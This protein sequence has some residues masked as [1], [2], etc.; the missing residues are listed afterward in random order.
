[1]IL[2]MRSLAGLGIGDRLDVAGPAP[3]WLE[4][5]A[6]DLAVADLDDLGPSVWELPD[7]VG[8]CKRSM[9]GFVHGIRLSSALLSHC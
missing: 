2:E 7:F 9:L 4:R 3:S 5:I 6:P 1:V 8:F